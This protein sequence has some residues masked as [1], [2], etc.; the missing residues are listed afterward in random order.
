[1]EERQRISSEL[2]DRL[3]SMLSTIKLLFSSL[4]EKLNI[5][6]TENQ[7]K[8]EKTNKLIDEACVEVRRISHNLGVGMVAGFGLENATN[9]LL[10]SIQATGKIRCKYS[11]FNFPN[12]IDLT[13]QIELF[14]VIQESVNNALKH[15]K[16][17]LISI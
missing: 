15:A 1:E 12:K 14:R 17:S 6:Q 10:E 11:S 4:E 2:H 7:Q 3:G 5:T 8:L 16:A 13:T 9:E